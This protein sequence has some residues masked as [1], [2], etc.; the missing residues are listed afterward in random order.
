M[1]KETNKQPGVNDRSATMKSAERNAAR[2]GKRSHGGMEIKIR[3]ICEECEENSLE[4]CKRC[5]ERLKRGLGRLE[6][7]IKSKNI[8]V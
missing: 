8:K 6:K 1:N 2:K 4:E 3:M 7:M 5:I